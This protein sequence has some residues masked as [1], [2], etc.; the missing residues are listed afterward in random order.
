MNQIVSPTNASNIKDFVSKHQG[1]VLLSII[2][3][4]SLLL[5][6][7][8]IWGP[9]ALYFRDIYHNY[10]SLTE[11]MSRSL[12]Q[13]ELPFWN[14]Y[15]F[16]GN[17][18]MAGFEPPLFYPLGWIFFLGLSFKNALLI[19][20]MSHHLL[21]AYGIYLIGR[22]YTWSFR[23]SLIA[24]ILF[25]F[26]G[27]MISM[28]N[29]HPLQNTCAWLPLVFF[30]AH[31]ILI[32][33]RTKYS[34]FFAVFF[35]L[36]ILSGHLEIVYIE[37]LFLILYTFLN[38]RFIHKRTLAVIALAVLLGIGLS[39]IQLIPGIFYLSE[40]IRSDGIIKT[41]SQTWSFHPLL[42][43]MMILPEQLGNIA[44]K[45]S[46]NMVFGEPKFGYSLF[47]L[48]SYLGALVLSLNIAGL[49]L[50]RRFLSHKRFVFFI[51]MAFIFLILSFGQFTPMHDYFLHLPGASFFRYPSK[52][53]FFTGFCL[54]ISAAE[55]LDA[56]FKDTL[57][58]VKFLH[59]LLLLGVLYL[60]VYVG[61]YFSQANLSQQLA[62][63]VFQLRPELAPDLQ[64]WCQH[65]LKTIL[66]QLK[67]IMMFMLLFWCLFF[68]SFK[69]NKP[70]YGGL[71]VIVTCL[72]L[73]SSGV[74]SL[75][76]AHVDLFEK[77][78]EIANHLKSIGLD[79]LPQYR[80]TVRNQTRKIPEQFEPQLEKNSYFR[81][82]YFF[83]EAMMPDY[84]VAYGFRNLSGAWSA[85]SRQM[86]EFDSY[87]EQAWEWN[88]GAFKQAYE[89]LNAV[90]YILIPETEPENASYY[91]NNSHYQKLKTFDKT[92][93]VLWEN[94]NSLPRAR[95]QYQAMILDTKE[96]LL[97]IMSQP[98]THGYD[99][100]NHLLLIDDQN[101]QNARKQIPSAESKDKKWTQPEFV[102]D[103]N[104]SLEI[105]FETN[106]SGYLV[107]AD[108]N[109]PGW[110]ALDNGKQTPILKANYFQRAV[111][112][113]PGK[114]L[115]RFEYDPPGF[116]L[117]L[118]ISSLAAI[119]W[120]GL[121]IWT[122]K[123][124]QT[125]EIL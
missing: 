45:Q 119:L 62:Q 96:Q 82:S 52:F 30:S 99:F 49:Y 98:V 59:I 20:L 22:V 74:N 47:F 16:T 101:F 13:G 125:A 95:F 90:K 78:S 112:V 107:L 93:M 56:V 64:N 24:A 17:P 117:G 122:R 9:Y 29:F 6:G 23:V 102:L 55:V 118:M 57:V 54:V 86:A 113:G 28:N 46:L 42:S 3:L 87:Y 77:P 7:H 40:S 38:V 50:C 69:H 123:S 116:K 115:I 108:Q 68:V 34:L 27:M 36:Q 10:Y 70:V 1:F 85:Y 58:Q 110:R 15:I 37:S 71:L 97:K 5:Y 8:L 111:R 109:L 84:S 124:S 25:S 43:V 94:K 106:T 31:Q 44:R 26:S 14:P 103:K 91:E 21:A 100:K 32:T 88:Q 41:Q 35:G 104:N 76:S 60:G 63:M 80:L 48:S 18:Q 51:I 65:L 73:F 89:A 121:L 81:T 19:N 53:L 2:L 92:Q 66:E 75:W 11:F 120:L 114:H 67:Q 72:D 12:H 4:L 61:I 105:A 79:Q 39:C 33:R 83:H